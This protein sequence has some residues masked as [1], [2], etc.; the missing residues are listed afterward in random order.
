MPYVTQPNK[1]GTWVMACNNQGELLKWGRDQNNPFPPDHPDALSLIT[2]LANTHNYR[3][4][5]VHVYDNGQLIQYEFDP[6]P[7][8]PDPELNKIA[9]ELEETGEAHY[10]GHTIYPAPDHGY[11][12]NNHDNHYET[13]VQTINEINGYFS[14]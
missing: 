1:V 14:E 7:Q 3:F 4:Y 10:K 12:I 6:A 11:Y 2:N 9:K 5:L 13:L 8:T